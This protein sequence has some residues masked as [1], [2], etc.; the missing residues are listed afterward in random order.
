MAGNALWFEFHTAKR[1]YR[2]GEIIS[3]VVHVD[4]DAPTRCDALTLSWYWTTHG[5]GN[6][7]VGTPLSTVLFA[8]EWQAGHHAIP[9]EVVC[10][11]LPLTYRGPLLN[12]DW[13]LEARADVPWAIDPKAKIDF[14]VLAP[15]NCRPE[16]RRTAAPTRA[17]TTTILIFGLALSLGGLG[18]A[19][20]SVLAVARGQIDDLSGLILLALAGL[21]V[22]PGWKLLGPRVARKAF[23]RLDS[24]VATTRDELS[25]TLEFT[26]R[27]PIE[28]LIASLVAEE[29]VASGHG[30]DRSVHTH[31]IHEQHRLPT[32]GPAGE[33]RVEIVYPMP[34][35]DQIGW[36]FATSDNALNWYVELNFDIEGWPDLIERI[37]LQ[38]TPA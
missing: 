33:H 17:R 8:G 32:V 11:S 12:I 2:P 24:K 3:G 29:V 18:T 23:D 6:L 27:K 14:S 15:A 4:A 25:V 36:S 9:F 16:V 13:I 1:E 20:A 5:R 21:L 28:S 34:D 35:F 38:I 30:T 10:P 37:E 26:S 19:L 7:A 31:R 22:W